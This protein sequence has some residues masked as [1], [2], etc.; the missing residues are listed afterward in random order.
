MIDLHCHSDCSDGQYSPAVL[1]AKAVA[2]GVRLLALTDH[3]TVAGLSALH[4]AAVGDLMTIIN[5]I[6]W[7]VRWKTLDVHVLGLNIDPNHEQ[8]RVCIVQQEELRIERAKK[9][10]LC[11]QALGVTNAY[12]K[13]CHKAGHLRVGRPHFAQV[14][15]DEGLVRNAQQAFQRYLVRGR[16]A[17]VITSWL[18][19]DAVIAA[20]T[21]AGGQAVLAHPLKYKL[22]RL[23]LHELIQ[24]FKLSGGVGIEVVSGAMLMPQCLE[25][26]RMCMKY[27]LFASSGSDYHGDK[28]SIRLGGQARLP[29]LCTP[30]WHQWTEGAGF[31]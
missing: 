9:I 1:L 2:C 8:I 28:S 14:L 25:M 15:V 29:A 7:S 22:T 17:Y 21:A 31:A 18:S 20:V 4:Q 26:A 16:A 13:A 19:L 30:I 12:D 10:A 24:A 3:D 11:L 5:G 6:E 23:K 27:D